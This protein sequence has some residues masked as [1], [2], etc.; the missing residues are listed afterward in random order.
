MGNGNGCFSFFMITLSFWGWFI[1]TFFDTKLWL[2]V[3]AVMLLAYICWKIFRAKNIIPNMKVVL[4]LGIICS[5][6]INLLIGITTWIA[7]VSAIFM[8][9]DFV[10]F[11]YIYY[12]CR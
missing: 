3:L 7:I 9:L 8:T 1:L 4:L 2:G 11:L 5:M 10:Y 6:C 12:E